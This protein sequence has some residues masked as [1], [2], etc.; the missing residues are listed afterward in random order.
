MLPH[1]CGN[2]YNHL[3]TCAGP[4]LVAT[5]CHF[6]IHKIMTC[7]DDPFLCAQIFP[8]STYGTISTIYPTRLRLVESIPTIKFI[9]GGSFGN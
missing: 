3:S 7:H 5:L 8:L 6:C 1:G 4:T 9:S 2:T